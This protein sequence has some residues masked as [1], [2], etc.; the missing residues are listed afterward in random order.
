[1]R[2]ISLIAAKRLCSLFGQEKTDPA[3]Q[4]GQLV[5]LHLTLAPILGPPFSDNSLEHTPSNSGPKSAPRAPNR[6]IISALRGTNKL[7]RFR[8]LKRRVVAVQ[9]DIC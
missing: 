9:G 5:A 3:G 4:P 7:R 6:P 2:R 8:G 1:M